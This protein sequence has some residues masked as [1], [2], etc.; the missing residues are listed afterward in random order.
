MTDQILRE[1]DLFGLR[2]AEAWGITRREL[3]EMWKAREKRRLDGN[4]NETGL[5]LS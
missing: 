5:D 4:R 3:W 1:Y 2:V